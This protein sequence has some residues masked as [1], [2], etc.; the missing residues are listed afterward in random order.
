M[1]KTIKKDKNKGRKRWI[2]KTII[3]SSETKE[4]LYN[5]WQLDRYNQQLKSEYKN[6]TKILGKVILDAKINM[7]EI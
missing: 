4:I 5:L 7:N 3:K 6:Y 1:V 2:T